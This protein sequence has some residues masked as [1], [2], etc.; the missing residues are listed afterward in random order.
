MTPGLHRLRRG[1]ILA[2]IGAVVLVVLLF[3]LSWFARS[4]PGGA[5]VAES[6]WSALPIL[7]WLIVLTI[8]CAIALAVLQATF[9][10][11]ALPVTMSVVASALAAITVLALVIRILTAALSPRLGAWLGL[12]AAIAMFTGGVLSMREEEGF[13]PDAEHPVERVPLDGAA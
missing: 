7:R 11:P 5:T 2:G 8:L 12:A 9:R 3:A 13:S 6:G 1:E 4:S 10:A